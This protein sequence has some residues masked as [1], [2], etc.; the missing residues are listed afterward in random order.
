MSQF[1]TDT[2]APDLYGSGAMHGIPHV[3]YFFQERFRVYGG[4]FFDGDTMKATIN[5]P[6]GVNALTEMITLMSSMP[7]GVESWGFGENLNAFM[8]GDIAMWESWPP[9]G[10]WAAGYGVEIEALSWLPK[11][12]V[13]GKVGYALPPG[14]TPQLAAGFSLSV[15]TDSDAKEAAYLFIQWLNSKDFSLKRVQLPFALR[16]PFRD[17]HFDSAEY[18]ALWPEA[19]QYLAALRKGA[20][21]GLLDLSIM[22][23]AKYE[24]AL[25]RGVSAAIGGEDPQSALDRVASEWDDFTE[26]VGLDRQKAA[27]GVWAAKPNAYP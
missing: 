16:D 9:V 17:S 7:P 10:R 1:L 24:D 4:K 14:G 19:P 25:A 27:Y 26:T 21:T 2:Y 8:A 11:S 15:S 12:T 22:S 3:H 20:V 5:S 18:Q 6:E 13:A 23:T